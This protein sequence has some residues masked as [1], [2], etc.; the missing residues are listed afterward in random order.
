MRTPIAWKRLGVVCV[1]ALVVGYAV[2]AWQR[3]RWESAAEEA[4][5]VLDRRLRRPEHAD[6]GSD[7]AA[8]ALFHGASSASK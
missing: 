8:T 3:W 2:G 1:T 5:T 6:R 7:S 4:S